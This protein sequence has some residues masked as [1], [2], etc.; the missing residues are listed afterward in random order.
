MEFR[1]WIVL[2]SCA[3]SAA[4]RM[5]SVPIVCINAVTSTLILVPVGSPLTKV[6]ATF[7]AGTRWS[8]SRVSLRELASGFDEG[9]AVGFD[10]S[11]VRVGMKVEERRRV[12][13]PMHR[14]G[15][16]SC[17]GRSSAM[18]RVKRRVRRTRLVRPWVRHSGSRAREIDAVSSHLCAMRRNTCRH[19]N[20]LPLYER[21]C[22]D[23]LCA[24][25]F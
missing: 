12:S 18:E 9:L 4:K 8:Q 1:P 17:G 21:D 2:R 5:N 13:L 14:I 24:G 20:T 10:L 11:I 22:G 15:T 7:A 6:F 3:S 19:E 25:K 16:M 23:S